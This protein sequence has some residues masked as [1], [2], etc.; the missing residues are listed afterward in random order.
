MSAKKKIKQND[1]KPKRNKKQLS[2]NEIEQL[3]LNAVKQALMSNGFGYGNSNA[4]KKKKSL[5]GWITKNGTVDQDITENLDTLRARSL[6]L[7]MSGGIAAGT[8]KKFKTNVIGSGL[9]LNSQIDYNFLNITKDKATEI[10]AQ[11]E[12]EFKIWSNNSYMCDTASTLDFYELQSLAFM[13]ML[14]SG[15]CFALLP[16]F[17]RAD[18]VYDL[19]VQ[20]IDASRVVD[21]EKIPKNA[22]C[23]AGIELDKYASPIAYHIKNRT[24]GNALTENS[25]TIRVEA[26]SGARRNVIHLFESERPEQ[27]RG[28][29]ILAPVLEQFKQLTRYS[30]AELTAA[31]ISALFTV[32]V[33]RDTEGIS[34][35]IGQIIPDEEKVDDSD[36]G[37]SLELGE[38]IIQEL[39]PGQKIEIA[40]SSRPNAQFDAFT[41]SVLKQI[42]VAL[43]IPY[44]VMIQHFS[45]SYS[46]S[47]AALLQAWIMFLNR[48]DWIVKKFCKPI[49]EEWMTE[50]VLNGRLRLPGY[51]SDPAIRAAYN[52][53]DFY[54]STMPQIDPVKEINAA[55][56]R[57]E[58]CFTTREQEAANFGGGNFNEV[59]AKRA[60]EEVQMNE[61]RKITNQTNLKYG[62]A[63][64]A[65]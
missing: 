22:D 24:T 37:P 40:N 46:A 60:S 12:R 3:K 27:R 43:E 18:H 41:S 58:Q 8:I 4:S 13:S 30:S 19:K 48:R 28:L 2:L 49:Y 5:A 57:V 25:T 64:N 52:R 62:N 33:T 11:I 14:L 6:D 36:S 54:G 51:F 55:T 10:E 45:S 1:V 65:N 42:G 61:V 38:G 47:R 59:V 15:D 35:P 50:A 44:E 32:F 29:P 39:D 63:K 9:Q 17:K 21:P 16:S 23:L 56:A 26:F 7:Y 31:V 20:I 53:A 34:S